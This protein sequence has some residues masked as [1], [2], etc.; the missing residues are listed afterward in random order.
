M[1]EA[2][3][4]QCRSSCLETR[5]FSHLL[6]ALH[7]LC[8]LKLQNLMKKYLVLIATLSLALGACE[9]HPASQLPNE[10]GVAKEGTEK[11]GPPEKKSA[12]PE[13]S[14]SGTPKTYFPQNP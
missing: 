7:D 3:A 10:E 14:P 12:T 5:K 6:R 8:V 1:D 11:S 13:T 2:M 9:R 4:D